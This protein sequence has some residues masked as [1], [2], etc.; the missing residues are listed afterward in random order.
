MSPSL[1]TLATLPLELR[2]KIWE[3][4]LWKE[5]VVVQPNGRLGGLSGIYVL[6]L[7]ETICSEITTGALYKSVT[8]VSESPGALLSL[9][10]NLKSRDARNFHKLRRLHLVLLHTLPQV[11]VSPD[12]LDDYDKISGLDC[13][14]DTWRVP[15]RQLPPNTEE[16]TL[17][18]TSPVYNLH[19]LP[20]YNNLRILSTVAY[21]KTK[22]KLRFRIT[23]CRYSSHRWLLQKRTLNVI[24]SPEVFV[25]RTRSDEELYLHEIRRGRRTRLD[26]MTHRGFSVEA[27]DKGPALMSGPL[28]LPQWDIENGIERL[29]RTF[30][31]ER[32][33]AISS[34]Y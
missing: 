20:R 25:F 19:G 18:V 31:I 17:D 15:F 12:Q 32:G 9:L 14:M 29:R 8:F 6:M 11:A 30:S 28:V 5:K 16:I 13:L 24:N 21:I 23:G 22:G 33:V 26:P 4:V 10:T 2:D 27:N 34:I 1:G 3:M 7:S